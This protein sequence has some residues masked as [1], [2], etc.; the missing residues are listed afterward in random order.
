MLLIYKLLMYLFYGHELRLLTTWYL[1]DF[2]FRY[3][4]E[5]DITQHSKALCELTTCLL[6]CL[7]IT[8]HMAKDGS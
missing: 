4:A 1:G 8:P 2:I 3:D 7:P 5:R 6:A